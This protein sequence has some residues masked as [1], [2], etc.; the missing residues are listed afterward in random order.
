MNIDELVA[1]SQNLTAIRKGMIDTIP[2]EPLSARNDL[3]PIG[4]SDLLAVYMNWIDRVIEPRPRVARFWAGFWNDQAIALAGLIIAMA[5]RSEKGDD[6]APYISTRVHTAGYAPGVRTRSG[7]ITGGKD[8]ALNA[9][10]TH[11]L[12]LVPGNVKGKRSGDSKALLFV[13]VKRDQMLFVMCGDHSSFDDGTLRQAVADVEVAAGFNIRGITGVSPELTAREG[14]AH[15]RQGVNTVTASNGL[16][17]A[18]SLLSCAL[19]SMRHRQHADEM[20]DAIERLE[21]L[22]RSD[23]GRIKVCEEFNFPY[24]DTARFGWALKYSTLYLVEESSGRAVAQVRY[25]NI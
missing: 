2:C 13:R 10:G 1:S 18:P 22:I 19:T 15:A 24:L 6:L 20:V 17:A 5:E 11:H 9:Y 21:P 14:E 16:F 8:R 4:F 25:R 23:K 12:H 3:R 7:L